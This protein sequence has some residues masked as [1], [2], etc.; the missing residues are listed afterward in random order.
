VWYLWRGSGYQGRTRRAEPVASKGGSRRL[1]PIGRWMVPP[2]VA[3]AGVFAG[4][5]RDFQDSGF[6]WP[7]ASCG[8]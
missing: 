1:E 5:C 3:A 6:A 7:C 4:G 2:Q 8:V